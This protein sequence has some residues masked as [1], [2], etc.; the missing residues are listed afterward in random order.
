MNAKILNWLSSYDEKF[1]SAVKDENKRSELLKQLYRA[2]V[3]FVWVMVFVVILM[4]AI[5]LVGGDPVE[6]LVLLLLQMIFYA[7]ADSRIRTLRLYELLSTTD[8]NS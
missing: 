2:R 4:V 7:D 6:L 5:L 1:W 3:T 8:K